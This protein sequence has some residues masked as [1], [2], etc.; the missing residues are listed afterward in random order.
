MYAMTAAHK[1]LPLPTYVS[2]TNLENNR[3]VVVRVNDRG[4]FHD[5][6]IIDLSY[7]AAKKLGIVAK[8]T[9]YVEVRALR[10]GQSTKQVATRPQPRPGT[11]RVELYLQAGAFALRTN[12]ERVRS[13]LQTLAGTLVNVLPATI[14]GISL[15]RVRLGPLEGIGHADRLTQQIVSLGYPTPQIILE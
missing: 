4:P 9:G 1:S 10:P 3:R 11:G 15:F 12:A 14:D 5:N 13:H 7:T 6:R 8:G 2:V